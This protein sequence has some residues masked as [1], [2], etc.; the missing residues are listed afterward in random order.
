MDWPPGYSY[1]PPPSPKWVKS[2]SHVRLFATPWTGQARPPAPP[3]LPGSSVHGIFQARILSPAL[4]ADSLPFKP[5]GN[6]F[7]WLASRRGDEEGIHSTRGGLSRGPKMETLGECPGKTM[8]SWSKRTDIAAAPLSF[9]S[10]TFDCW[11]HDCYCFAITEGKAKRILVP[12]VLTSASNYLPLDVS[13]WEKINLELSQGG[14]FYLWPKAFL[15]A[16]PLPGS[17]V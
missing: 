16:S 11:H 8:L 14:L 9:S 5:P 13:V 15:T 10:S 2:F 1:P 12:P 4:Q 17:P 7:S 6:P 3:P